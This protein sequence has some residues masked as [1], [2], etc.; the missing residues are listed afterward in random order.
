MANFLM[1]ASLSLPKGSESYSKVSREIFHSCRERKVSHRKIQ[2]GRAAWCSEEAHLEKTREH[3]GW[4]APDDKKAGV[5]FPQ[6]G[7]QVLQTLQKKPEEK[8]L[9]VKED[10]AELARRISRR[11]TW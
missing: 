4:L 5:E 7:I 1:A 11:K 6:V 2:R 10:D 3:I 8:Y 9:R